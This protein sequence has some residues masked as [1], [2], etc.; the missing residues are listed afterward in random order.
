MNGSATWEREPLPKAGI[1]LLYNEIIG[2]RKGVLEGAG[3]QTLKKT[4]RKASVMPSL[5]RQGN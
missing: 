5:L 3:T 2:Q 1:L 4:R